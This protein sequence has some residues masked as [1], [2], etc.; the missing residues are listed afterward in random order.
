MTLATARRGGTINTGLRFHPFLP[1]REAGPMSIPIPDRSSQ[2][3]S[4]LGCLGTC[5]AIA[6]AGA[7]L[8]YPQVRKAR[9]AAEMAQLT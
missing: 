4:F 5:L 1:R 7:G 9:R 8:L 2:V 3:R 6:A